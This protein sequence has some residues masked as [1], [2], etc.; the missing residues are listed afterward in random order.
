MYKFLL[1]STKITKELLNSILGINPVT[2]HS[3][4][5]GDEEQSI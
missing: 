4:T 2:L 1:Y 3:A 5:I